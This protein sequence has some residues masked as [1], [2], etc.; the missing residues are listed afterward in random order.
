MQGRIV[1][2]RQ[3]FLWPVAFFVEAR[4]MLLVSIPSY[5]SRRDFCALGA[6]F[7]SAWHLWLL[8]LLSGSDERHPRPKAF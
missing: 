3:V 7:P 5:C 2:R 4:P 6:G 8:S 1:F